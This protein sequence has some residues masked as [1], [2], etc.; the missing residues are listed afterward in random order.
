MFGIQGNHLGT[1]IRTADRHWVLIGLSLNIRR[2]YNLK[3]LRSCRVI[4]IFN[5][6]LVTADLIDLAASDLLFLLLPF[7]WFNRLP[8]IKGAKTLSWWWAMKGQRLLYDRKLAADPDLDFHIPMR[9]GWDFKC[10][11]SGW[12]SDLFVLLLKFGVGI[13][14]QMMI[15]PC[16]NDDEFVIPTWDIWLWKPGPALGIHVLH[17][18]RLV[19]YQCKLY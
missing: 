2:L 8:K 18:N 9:E 17:S 7:W 6:S 19:F 12:N 13:I 3:T 10:G 4:F 1:I 16:Q 14:R 15:M 11:G 5:L